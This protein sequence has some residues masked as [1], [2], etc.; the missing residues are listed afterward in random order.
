MVH[1]FSKETH[2]EKQNVIIPNERRYY[3]REI[4]ETVRNYHKKADEQVALARRLFQVEGA[5]ESVK[6][7]EANGEI[8]ASLEAV[9][10]I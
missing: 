1:I 4:T 7:R 3:L 2:V 10:K 8:L 5:I 9:K 6:E